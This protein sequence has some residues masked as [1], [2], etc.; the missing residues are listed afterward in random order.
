[1]GRL[2]WQQ[3]CCTRTCPASGRSSSDCPCTYA[4]HG[5]HSHSEMYNQCKSEAAIQVKRFGGS[6]SLFKA[7]FGALWI[8]ACLSVQAGVKAVNSRQVYTNKMLR[9]S[10]KCHCDLKQQHVTREQGHVATKHPGC[11]GYLLKSECICPI[12]ICKKCCWANLLTKPWRFPDRPLQFHPNKVL[13]S[14]IQ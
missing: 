5:A 12:R 2:D 9:L 7:R 14:K 11:A 3:G 6:G 1:M 13:F 10:V 4:G 8:Q